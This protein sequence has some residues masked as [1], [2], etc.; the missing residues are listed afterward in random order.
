MTKNTAGRTHWIHGQL[1][2]Q[3][4]SDKVTAAITEQG[5]IWGPW[6]SRM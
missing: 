3:I 4:V 6:E 2:W 5:G 1:S